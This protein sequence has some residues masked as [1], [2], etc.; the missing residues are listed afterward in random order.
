L[1][2]TVYSG[3]CPQSTSIAPTATQTI[4]QGGTTNALAATVTL[5]GGSG[6]PTILYQWYYNNSNS[7]TIAGATKLTG[8][9][10]ST[11]TPQNSTSGTRYYFCVGYATDNGCGQTDATQILASNAVQV[12]INPPA[13]SAPGA[14][15]GP[16][17][18]SPNSTGITYSIA[19][20]TNATSYEWSVPMGW[21]LNSGQGTTSISVT[22]GS[23]GQNGY[24][25]VSASNSCGT[26]PITMKNVTVTATA[27]TITLG[28]IQTICRGTTTALLPYSATT[29]NPDNYSIDY[30]STANTAGFVDVTDATLPASPISLVVPAA[31]AAGN[32]TGSL[33]VKNTSTGLS[34]IA[35]TITIRVIATPATPGAISGMILVAQN[36]PGNV[37]S[38][39][40]VTYATTYNWAVPAGWT[41]SAGQ[42][43]SSITVTTGAAGQNGNISVTASNTCGTSAASNLAV[44]S[45]VPTDHATYGC[46]SCHIFHSATG[47]TLTT[48]A[49]NANLCISCHQTGAPA[50]GKPLSNAMKAIP[51]TS[52]TSHSWDVNA[53]N[54]T[55]ETVSPTN[56]EMSARL[57]NGKIVCSTC[58]NQHNSNT[59]PSYLR[60]AN[61]GDALCKECHTPR[62]VGRYTDNTATNKGSHPVGLTYP[63]ANS[64]YKT[65][66]TAPLTAPG[67]KIECSSCH[68]THYATTTDGNLLRA[69]VDAAMC[70][71][72]HNYSS[73]N[74]MNCLKCHQTHNTNKSNIFMIRNT[75]ATPN[76]GT[77]TVNFTVRT[78]TNSF[79]D[80]NTTYDGICEVC[81][82]STDH[83]RNNGGG[84]DQNHSS[85]G[86]GIPGQNCT[87][88]HSHSSNF[89]TPNCTDC[90]NA[91]NTPT[92]GIYTTDAHS[93]HV[94][95][96]GYA[97]STCH[98]GQGSGGVNEPT[99]PS[100]GLGEVTFDP[101]GL[102]KRNGLDAATP[103]Y[104][105]T[106]KT[107]TNV[108]C[109]SNGRSAYRGTDGTYTWS[110]TTG[111]QTP[112]YGTAPNWYTGSITAC[113]SCH[114]GSG[115][116]NSPY[117]ITTPGLADP[118]PP[119]TGSHQ[120]GAHT[121]NSQELSGNGWAAV[122]CFWCHN[123][124]N[125]NSTTTMNQGTYGT[126]LHVDGQTSFKPLSFVN[127]GTMVNATPS[128][129]GT[130]SYSRTGSAAHCS[131]GKTCW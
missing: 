12:T 104:N 106:A 33:R 31:V 88:C 10:N 5:S 61:T 56:T 125:G 110:G 41:I 53:V 30:N 64:N 130:F 117:T 80:G 105:N 81:H 3:N 22:A 112:T 60:I 121:S 18:A 14:I 29:E 28:T 69:T 4:C 27:P 23:L 52:G 20:V 50:S 123:A 126:A 131:Q 99:H 124:N 55:R 37:Y 43:T 48:V 1:A 57:D 44:Q 26:S 98:F 71:S 40:P 36:T 77:K 128:S 93:T 75:I 114:S 65:S 86:A 82:T 63:T 101:N 91:I 8:E 70:T 11:Y 100:G 95:R 47:T 24:I 68:Q 92:T 46:N 74:G 108:Y 109:H 17:T 120:R 119:A 49:G 67:G 115:N 19:P 38:I 66:P 79:A 72:C 122:N 102:A 76:S 51:G 89:A 97:C 78:G 16:S 129:G 85:Q 42:G 103:T 7:N 9:T 2:V 45:V 73:H 118:L 84:S 6:T 13:P 90:H 15:T 32:Y 39:S 127:G 116:M 83:F 58:H 96:Y 111:S 54:A 35:Y 59:N 113:S 34:S 21:T 107:C 62:N 87:T 94:T 25:T